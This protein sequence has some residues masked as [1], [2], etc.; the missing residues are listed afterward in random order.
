VSFIR[1]YACREGLSAAALEAMWA[2]SKNGYNKS[3]DPHFAR[4]EEH[5]A[6]AHGRAGQ[7]SPRSISAG[8]VISFLQSQQGWENPSRI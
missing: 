4:F 1:K 8:D 5:F 3:H 7:L 2:S 6:Q